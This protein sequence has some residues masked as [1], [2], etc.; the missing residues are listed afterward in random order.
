MKR[1]GANLLFK[2][3]VKK[4]RHYVISAEVYNIIKVGYATDFT[5]EYSQT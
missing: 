4:T 3:K 5:E 1:H 2:I